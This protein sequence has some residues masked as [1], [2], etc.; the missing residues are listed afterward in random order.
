MKLRNLS[1]YLSKDDIVK[2]M[3]LQEK[4]IIKSLELKDLIKITGSYKLMG[5]NINFNGIMSIN[6]YKNNIIFIDIIN[7]NISNKTTSNPLVKGSLAILRKSINDI[8]GIN[9]KNNQLTIDI[10]KIVKVYC[11]EV[12]GIKLKQ[13]V[14][15]TLEIK[16]ETLKFGINLLELN[17]DNLNIN[18]K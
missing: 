14:I 12:Y 15:N 7:F 16:N 6:S 4:V 2:L 1:L 5:M 13:L 3:S 11:T 10:E 17:L 8:E 18:L 9:L